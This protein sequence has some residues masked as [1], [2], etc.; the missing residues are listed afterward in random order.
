MRKESRPDKLHYG[1]R[2]HSTGF[3]RYAAPA[4][5]WRASIKLTGAIPH[6]LCVT[7][8]TVVSLETSLNPIAST[9]GSR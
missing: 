3:D 5:N 4:S 8:I 1:R 9:L 7:N 2:R 6:S